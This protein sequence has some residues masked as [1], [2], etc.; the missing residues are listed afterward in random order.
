MDEILKKFDRQKAAKA[1]M[2]AKAP[3]VKKSKTF[4]ISDVRKHKTENDF[5]LVMSKN[6]YNMSGFLSEHPGGRA[7]LEK[8]MGTGFDAKMDFEDAE[9]S[10]RAKN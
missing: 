1:E 5:W 10:K 2:A 7:V 8:F 4:S 9:H 3:P 6:V